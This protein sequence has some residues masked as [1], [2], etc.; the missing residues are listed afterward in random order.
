MDPR[1][2]LSRSAQRLAG[3]L[4]DDGVALEIDG[5]M[6]GLVLDELDYSRRPRVFEQRTPLYGGFVVPDD[7]SLVEAGELVDVVDL[8]HL[9]L[10]AARRF[11]DG[12]STYLVR[13][14]DGRLQLA[15]F[16]RSVQY[17]ADMVEIQDN[18][19]AYIVQRT[20]MGTVRLFT[21]D[22]TVEWTGYRWS[23][24]PSAG[25]Q[26]AALRPHLPTVPAPVLAGVL[27]LALHWLSPSRVGATLV[28]HAESRPR[29]LDGPTDGLDLE[30]SIVAPDLTVTARHHYPALFAALSQTDL[31][32]LV[33]ARGTVRRVGVGLRS[34]TAAENAVDDHR[35]MRHRSA[36]RY[37]FDHPDA[38]AVVVSEDGPVTVF[39]GGRPLSE[40]AATAA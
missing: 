10:G 16:Q 36:A 34:S 31:A 26:Y 6:L 21:S 5:A 12:R 19:G 7:R 17:E 14:L 15:C 39:H 2:Q 28:V 4:D 29:P 32:V 35:G 11:S 18:T 24:R 1:V 23:T 33:D 25:S 8:D 20:V 3:E 22:G 9:E 27:K 37:T 40:C 30:H 38:V 13:H